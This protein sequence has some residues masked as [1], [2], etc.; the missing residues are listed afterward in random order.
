MPSIGPERMRLFALDALEEAVVD[1]EVGPV[2]RTRAL[3]LALAYLTSLHPRIWARGEPYRDFWRATF[4]PE[5]GVRLRE[6]EQALRT[7][8]AW[9]EVKRD[10]ERVAVIRE[11][12]KEAGE[13]A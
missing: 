5:R 9:A 8:Y 12:A 2:R 10:E 6:M 4:L 1:G 11:R 13:R 7:I 3:R